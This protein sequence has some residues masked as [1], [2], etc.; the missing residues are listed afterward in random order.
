MSQLKIRVYRGDDSHLASTVTIPGG[1][2]KIAANL[3]PRR[4]IEALRSEG[5]D[6][7]EIARLADNPEARGEL[8]TVEDHDK[9]ER[10]IISLE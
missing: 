7:A 2:L 8:V 9:G 6:P 3:L 10:V 5:M 1:I 4:A